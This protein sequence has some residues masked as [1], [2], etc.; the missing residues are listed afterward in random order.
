MLQPP[1]C[2]TFEKVVPDLPYAF[3]P[4][5]HA[6]EKRASV[7]QNRKL[8]VFHFFISR[9]VWS[10]SR[11]FVLPFELRST[12]IEVIAHRGMDMIP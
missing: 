11:H 3:R 5:N 9:R 7:R 8:P 10:C 2:R 1:E 12:C 6:C 4:V